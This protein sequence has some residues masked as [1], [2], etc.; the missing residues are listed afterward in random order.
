MINIIKVIQNAAPT[1]GLWGDARTDE[2]QL[3]ASYP[4]LEWAMEVMEKGTSTDQFDNRQKEV[5]KI[6]KNQ[7]DQNQHKMQPIPVCKIPT[8]FI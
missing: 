6:F 8:A 4:E 7:F 3:G 2:D 1:D 5:F